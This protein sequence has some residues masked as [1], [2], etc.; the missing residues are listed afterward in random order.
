MSVQ[1]R[2]AATPPATPQVIRHAGLRWEIVPGGEQIVRS[3]DDWRADTLR[4]DLADAIVHTR[5]TE[6]FLLRLRAPGG[7]AAVKVQLSEGYKP[8]LRSLYGRCKARKEWENHLVAAARGVPTVAPLA[9]GEFRNPLLVHEAILITQ[10]HDHVTT[11][12]DW[13]RARADRAGDAEALD[14]AARI[15]RIT[16]QAQHCGIYHN[17]IHAGNV[18]I[19][20]SNGA[21][22]LL[23]VDWKHA[24]LKRR[25]AANDAQNLVRTAWFMDRSLGQLAD[26]P[27]TDAEKQAFLTAYLEATADR[28]DRADLLARLRAACPDASWIPEELPAR[29]EF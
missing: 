14:L 22:R 3:R 23:L 9:L 2:Q 5:D 28:R 20:G 19:A 25:T 6:R 15:A 11:V 12:L 8:K 16:A 26:A 24:R 4:R 18:M 17:E 1:P 29:K 21:E 10:W 27:P 13:R 7:D